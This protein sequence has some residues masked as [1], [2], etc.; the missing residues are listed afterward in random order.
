MPRLVS[1]DQNNSPEDI[2]C[3]KLTVPNSIIK[4]KVRLLLSRRVKKS[5]IAMPHNV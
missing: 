2:K 4:Q 5:K 3:E 1:F